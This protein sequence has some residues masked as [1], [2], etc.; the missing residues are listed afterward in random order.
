MRLSA[1]LLILLPA[2]APALGCAAEDR[3]LRVGGIDR[4]Y[5]VEFPE[6]PG[7]R[8]AIIALHGTGGTA[9]GL[10][11]LTDFSLDQ[12]G[13]VEVYPDAV[14]RMW[15][16]GLSLLSVGGVGV[17]NDV[18]FIRA[19]VAA[20]AAEGR[21]DPDR[22]YFVGFSNGGAM[23]LLL[24]CQAPELVAGAAIHVMT[25]PVG[26]ACPD[27]GPPVPMM[28]VLGTHDL[29][30]P[31]GGGRISWGGEDRIGVRSAAETL[32]FF[33]RRNRCADRSERQLADR[34]PQ[35]GTRVWLVDYRDCAAPLVAFIVKGGGHSWAGSSAPPPLAGLFGSTSQD[36]SATEETQGFLRRLAGPKGE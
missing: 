3:T 14:G 18:D 2:L 36:I 22:V 19:L 16:D 1:L 31:F 13:W 25:L 27:A 20:L 12:H 28:F 17:G 26:L 9:E 6:T 23:T 8:P 35:D 24:I 30:I 4:H 7:P 11:R 34:D 15:S 32:A 5:V 33:A 21:V 29:L 10:R